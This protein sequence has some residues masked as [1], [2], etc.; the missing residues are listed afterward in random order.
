MLRNALFWAIFGAT[1]HLLAGDSPGSTP[2]D[3]SLQNKTALIL[4]SYYKGYRWTDDENRGIDSVLSPV[5]GAANIY[6]EYMDTKRF[7]GRDSLEQLSEVYR[8]RLASHHFDVIVSTDN[9]AFDFLRQYRDRLFPGTPVVFCGVSYFQ[10]DDLKGHRLFT[11]VSE[12]ADV[13]DTLELAL[14]LHPE[15]DHVYVV[16]EVTETGQTVHDEIVKLMP[17]YAGSVDFTF[18]ENYSMPELLD[19]LRKLPAHSLVFYS[20]FSRDRTGRFFE[21]DQSAAAIAGASAAPVYGAWDFNLGFGIVGGKLISGFYQGETAGKIALRVLRGESADTIPVVRFSP[22]RPNRYIFDYAQLQRWG[23]R[24]SALPKGSQIVNQ[25]ES[26]FLRHRTASLMAMGLSLFLI[27][28]NSILV[29]NVRRRRAAEKA[30]WEHQQHLEELVTSRSAQLEDLNSR[31]RLDIL[32]R[33]GTERALRES[34]QLLRKTFASLRDALFIITSDTRLIVDCNPA[35]IKLFG[36]SREELVGKSIRLL[37]VDDAAFLH[38]RELAQPAIREKGYLHIAAFHMK[39][40][41]GEIF[42]TQHSVMP[43]YDE[44]GMMIRW[45]SV[46]RDITEETRTSRKLEQYRG[47][48][49]K[50]AAELTVVEARERKAIAAQL[51]ENLGQLLATVKMKLG[52]LGTVAPDEPLQPRVAEVQGLVEEALQQTR[53]LTY[54]LSP[55]VLYQLGLEAALQWLAENMERQYA[56]R[57]VFTRQ[58]ESGVLHEESSVFLFSA[59]RE[60]LVN[61][62][63]HACATQ[64]AVRLRWLEDWVDVLVKDNGK[65]FPRPRLSADSDWAVGTAHAQDGFGLFNIQ[66]RVSDLGGRM[67]LRSQ[68]NS[69]TAVK[70]RLPLDT[71]ARNME[72]EYEHQNSTG[73]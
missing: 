29:L 7:A 60:L 40:K 42:S 68:P 52:P 2:A 73:R 31:L 15:T 28:V 44:E 65:G 50:L 26:F 34:Q 16:N 56:Y 41:N 6:I 4:H 33:Q 27:V 67:G 58:G 61:V 63:K 71:A 72:T 32:K 35:A 19:T 1:A 13:K 10:Q 12:E 36:Y 9:N 24:F 25:P 64:V 5:L 37:H 39:R 47:K 66:E 49:R 8:Q 51:H 21:Y 53:S 43:L 20:F 46:V 62:A 55:P 23:I 59:V 18:L 48:L 3:A 54:Q 70:I 30:L 57:V 69:G 22:D 17:S 14:R 38:F 11:G 45:V